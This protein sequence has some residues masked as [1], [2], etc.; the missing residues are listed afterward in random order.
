[1]S[2]FYILTLRNR[3]ARFESY[4]RKLETISLITIIEIQ[5]FKGR[6][7]NH[8]ILWPI[9]LAVDHAK[10]GRIQSKYCVF[11]QKLLKIASPMFINRPMND[12]VKY[13][14]MA[15][16][17]VEYLI[18]LLTIDIMVFY[19]CICGWF[20]QILKHIKKLNLEKYSKYSGN[21]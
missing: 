20:Y 6:H 9:I 3:L 12:K 15:L 5:N 8:L 11:Q 21:K 2:I 19:D 4:Q 13:I 17:W 1:M 14:D 18:E 10:I 7:L 16:Q